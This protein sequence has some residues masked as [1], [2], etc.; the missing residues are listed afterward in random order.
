[1]HEIVGTAGVDPPTFQHNV[2]VHQRHYLH[3][4][5]LSGTISHSE[6]TREYTVAQK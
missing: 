5:H 2:S 1:M 4:D 3:L 6:N